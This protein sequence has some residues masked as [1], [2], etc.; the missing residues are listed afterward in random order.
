MT[1]FGRSERDAPFGR[2]I[3]EIQ[4]VNRKYLEIYISMPKEF[5]RFENEI[6]KLIG[7]KVQRGLVSLRVHLIPNADA[8]QNLLPDLTLLQGLKDGWTEL[9]VKLGYPKETIDLSF[10]VQNLP[11]VSPMKLAQEEDFIPLRHCLE[12]ALQALDEMKRKE[13]TTLGKDIAE[14]LKIMQGAIVSIE[15]KAPDI[16]AKTKQKLKERMEEALQPGVELDERL[17]REAALFAERVDISEELTRFR[18]H[19]GQ[20]EEL[21]RAKT[22]ASGRKMDFLV[23]EM[24]REINTIGSKSMD[25]AIAHIVVDVKSE[26]EK[27]RE[28]IQNIE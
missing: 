20:Y 9:A 21:L 27:V 13:G 23:Q 15:K 8:V 6:R 5:T 14:R 19:V 2:L 26:L 28:Q 25:A 12:E 24:G 17:L 16:V 3:A 10:L 1:G 7:E 4:S 22:G 18:S 11:E